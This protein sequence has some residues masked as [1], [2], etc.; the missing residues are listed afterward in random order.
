MIAIRQIKEVKSGA[1]TIDLPL[2][3]QAK[4]VE[5]IILPLEEREKGK[6]N[7]PDLL[8][9]APTLMDNELHEFERVREWM[10]I[11]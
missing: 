1:I 5:I 3:F 11:T 4:L 2:N 9:S 6:Q 7:L 10:Q 8:L